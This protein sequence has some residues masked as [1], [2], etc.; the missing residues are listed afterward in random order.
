MK[1]WIIWVI[2]RTERRA[3]DC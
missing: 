3:S 1:D 2:W